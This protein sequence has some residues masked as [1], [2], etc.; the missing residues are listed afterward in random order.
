MS[1]RQL[2]VSARPFRDAG[3]LWVT[4]LAALFTLNDFDIEGYEMPKVIFKKK[5]K[6]NF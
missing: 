4:Q 6:A 3:H 5:A 2:L 1:A